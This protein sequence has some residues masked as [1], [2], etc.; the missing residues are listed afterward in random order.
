[1]RIGLI[2]DIHSNAVA[3][4]AVLKNMGDVDTI[5]CAGDIVGYGPYP[6]E[7]IELLKQYNVK[8]VMGDH[9]K[10]IITGDT[11]WF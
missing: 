11:E 1:M 2:A 10:A 7:T 6:N 9:D 4:A 8:C 3:L 5:I